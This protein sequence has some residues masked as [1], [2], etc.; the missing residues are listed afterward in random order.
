MID[1]KFIPCPPVAI[2]LNGKSDLIGMLREKMIGLE[3]ARIAINQY[4]QEE[5]KKMPCG[6]KKKGRKGGKYK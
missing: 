6:G 3:R 4:V 1:P 2:D 5:R